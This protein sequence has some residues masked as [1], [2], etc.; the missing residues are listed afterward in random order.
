MRKMQWPVEKRMHGKEDQ[1]SI[2]N[3]FVGVGVYIII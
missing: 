2:Q 3:T 1:V